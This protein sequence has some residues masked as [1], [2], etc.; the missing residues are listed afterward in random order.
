MQSA[1]FYGYGLYGKGSNSPVLPIMKHGP[2]ALP[3]YMVPVK[4]DNLLEARRSLYP[5]HLSVIF[6]I[7]VLDARISLLMT[8]IN[9]TFNME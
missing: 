2:A 4:N 9:G 1:M 7:S 3:V 8:S 5:N 6:S